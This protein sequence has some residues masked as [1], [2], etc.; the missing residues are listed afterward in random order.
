MEE[1]NLNDI[2]F[3][4]AV[5]ELE[6]TVSKLESGDLPL[7]EALELY[8]RGQLLAAYCSKQLEIAAL[9]VEMLTGDG[10]LVEVIQE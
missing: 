3:E 8:E 2:P 10:E 6:A 4:D 1:I 5:A 7:E 9:R